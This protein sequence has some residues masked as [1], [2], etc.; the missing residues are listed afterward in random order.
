MTSKMLCAFSLAE[1]GLYHRSIRQ[2]RGLLGLYAEFVNK[3]LYSFISDSSLTAS[4]DGAF[5]L[6]MNNRNKIDNSDTSCGNIFSFF[7]CIVLVV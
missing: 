2:S 3:T 6:N 4:G 7:E 5:C 1:V